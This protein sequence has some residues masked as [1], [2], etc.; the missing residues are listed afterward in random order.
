MESLLQRLKNSRTVLEFLAILNTYMELNGRG[1]IIITG[2]FA[3]ELYTN[4]AYRTGV[5]DI[6]VEGD[7][8]FVEN[9]LSMFGK[10]VSRVWELE[11]FS[12]KAIDIVSTMYLKPKAPIKLRVNEYWIYIEPVEEILI[13]C[14]AACKFWNSISD[15]EKAIMLIICQRDIIDW[16]Y[17]RDRASR[18]QVLDKLEELLSRVR[19][20]VRFV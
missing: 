14:L 17:L 9:I 3:V 12:D 6:I 7:K 10:R 15:C 2:G 16:N 18:E 8:T 13:T 4:R 19:E 1:R 20:H 5:V 11:L